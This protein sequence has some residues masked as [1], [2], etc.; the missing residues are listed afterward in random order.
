MLKGCRNDYIEAFGAVY[1]GEKA[2]KKN[3]RG[4]Q[5]PPPFGG[6]GLVMVLLFGFQVT[7]ILRN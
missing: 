3:L 4:L 5:Q 6:Q 7:V 2:V 1:W